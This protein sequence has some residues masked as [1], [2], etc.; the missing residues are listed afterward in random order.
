MSLNQEVE[1]SIKWAKRLTNPKTTFIIRANMCRHARAILANCPNA[2]SLL[3]T[4]IFIQAAGNQIVA[5]LQQK[6]KTTTIQ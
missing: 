3:A 5:T 4:N 1:F 6:Q 2:Y